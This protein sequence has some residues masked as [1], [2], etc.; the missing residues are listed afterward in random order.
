M[1]CVKCKNQATVKVQNLDACNECFVKIIE[2]RVRKELRLNKLIKKN[3]RIFLIDDDSAEFHVSNYLL[4]R[5]IKDLPVTI[6][7]KKTSFELG[8]EVKEICD[9]VIIPWNADKED[10]YFLNCVFNNKEMPYLGHYK[11]KSKT[12][13]KLLRPVL[14]SEVQTFAKIK[15]FKYKKQNTRSSISEMIDELETEYPE[16]KFSLLKSSREITKKNI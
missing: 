16:I 14:H 12:Y 7:T 13:V 6:T 4:P 5:I 11:I 3:D 10:E 9:K 8:K 2:K 1:N 15:K